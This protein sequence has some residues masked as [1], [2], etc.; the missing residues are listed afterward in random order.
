LLFGVLDLDF[1]MFRIAL[2]IA[3]VPAQRFKEKVNEFSPYLC[4]VICRLFIN[5]KIIPGS[6]NEFSQFLFWYRTENSYRTLIN[7]WHPHI[8]FFCENTK[9]FFTGGKKV[10]LV[11]L[12]FLKKGLSKKTESLFN[13]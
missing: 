11:K 9:P 2:F 13:Y 10:S 7:L 4:F 6:F 1:F 12:S 3:H 5:V 8:F